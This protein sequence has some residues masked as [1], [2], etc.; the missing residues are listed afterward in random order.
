VA[1]WPRAAR[2]CDDDRAEAG[3]LRSALELQATRVMVD[4]SVE[5]ICVV[6]PSGHGKQESEE[7]QV[8]GVDSVSTFARSDS[9]AV[10]HVGLQHQE[11]GHRG[12]KQ[13][14]V[15]SGASR[16]TEL[17][18]MRYCH[19]IR[20]S[21]LCESSGLSERGEGNEMRDKKECHT[22]KR[23]DNT[24]SNSVC[25]SL[26]ARLAPTVLVL[27][28]ALLSRLNAFCQQA[29]QGFENPSPTIHQVTPHPTPAPAP[30][31]TPTPTC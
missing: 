10:I 30:A 1:G 3:G 21:A 9:D 16:V 28:Q 14:V 22:G 20:S 31:S 18:A 17:F 23:K 7:V 29:A 6:A 27:D 5:S 12:A 26:W 19:V 8:L 13:G 2:V 4:V 24:S 11:E 25:N 15:Q